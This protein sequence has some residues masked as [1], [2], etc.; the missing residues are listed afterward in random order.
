[1]VEGSKHKA[2]LSKVAPGPEIVKNAT[3][4]KEEDEPLDTGDRE[5]DQVL[6][7]NEIEALE[8]TPIGGQGEGEQESKAVDKALRIVSAQHGKEDEEFLRQFYAPTDL[9]RTFILDTAFLS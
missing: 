4:K 1:M 5:D 3:P 8:H 6:G 2:A 7:V 9:C